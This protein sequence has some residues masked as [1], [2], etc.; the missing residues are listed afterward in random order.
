MEPIKYPEEVKQDEL[1]RVLRLNL[2][3]TDE[4]PYCDSPGNEKCAQCK[5]L[6]E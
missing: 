4:K 2:F 3:D 1:D 6:A 5:G